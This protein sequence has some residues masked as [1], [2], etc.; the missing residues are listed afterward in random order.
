MRHF[1]RTVC[2]SLVLSG[3][4]TMSANQ[5]LTGSWTIDRPNS[6]A[7]DP[8]RRIHL[9]ITVAGD[10][11]EIS[12]EV[13]TG[14]RNHTNTYPL[15]IDQTVAVPIDWWTGNRHIGAYMGG[16]GTKKVRASW[17]DGGDTLRVEAHFVLETSQIETPVRTY[18]E[19]R[20]SEDGQ[21]LTVLEL[22]SSRERPI[23]YVFT[24]D[25]T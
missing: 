23:V 18:T 19:Y 7:I 9:D 21:R 6:T 12:R 11:V 3:P 14:R 17:I 13:T 16:D 25:D 4:L 5:D 2:L 1:L 10:Q 8:W 20:L 15:V 22:R 24:R